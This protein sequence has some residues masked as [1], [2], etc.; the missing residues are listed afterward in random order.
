MIYLRVL[1]EQCQ[2]RL[3][4]HFCHAA[5]VDGCYRH[6]LPITEQVETAREVIAS[7]AIGDDAFATFMLPRSC[8]S[9][10][11][12]FDETLQDQ[13][14]ITPVLA[15]AHGCLPGYEDTHFGS[16]YDVQ[17]VGIRDLLWSAQDRL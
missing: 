6:S 17:Q 8:C 2:Q 10:P 5:R 12:N 11:C 1:L 3:A 13:V 4:R 16:C 15:F 9:A 14:Q 7:L